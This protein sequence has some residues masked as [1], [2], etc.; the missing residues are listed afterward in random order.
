MTISAAGHE[1]WRTGPPSGVPGTGTDLADVA[2]EVAATGVPLGRRSGVHR[3][4][5]EGPLPGGRA[6]LARPDQVRG[7]RVA[8]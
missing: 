7:E 2:R 4:P 1:T 6:G 3:T 8:P 5:Y